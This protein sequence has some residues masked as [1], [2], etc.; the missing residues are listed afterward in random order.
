MASRGAG[1]LYGMLDLLIL[2]TLST[3]GPL[4]GVEIANHI[5]RLSDST[6]HIEEGSLYP[7][8]YRLQNKEFV[9]WEWK[10]SE[11]GQRAKYYTLSPDGE[12]ALQSRMTGW[13]RNTRTM[14]K[15][16]DLSLEVLQ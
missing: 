16:L 6:L 8:L 14:L 9:D 4:H 15:V 13:L 12:K 2:K 10:S 1:S 5:H 3:S 7:A 11:K